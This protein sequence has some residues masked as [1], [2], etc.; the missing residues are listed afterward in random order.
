MYDFP[1]EE[2]FRAE[3]AGA[4]IRKRLRHRAVVGD[5]VRVGPVELVVREIKNDRIVMV[6]LELEPEQHPLMRRV[7]RAFGFKA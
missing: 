7:R 3:P 6:G 5:R 2:K 1:V 4:Y